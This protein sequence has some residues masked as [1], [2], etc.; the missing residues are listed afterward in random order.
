MA[1]SNTSNLVGSPKQIA[2]A[3]DIRALAKLPAAPVGL[4]RQFFGWLQENRPAGD[5]KTFNHLM[6]DRFPSADPSKAM[7]L[8]S[9]DAALRPVAEGALKGCTSASRWIDHRD[10]PEDIW[11]PALWDTLTNQPA[12]R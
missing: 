8:S 6:K 4:L 3:E 5:L 1:K 12:T 10:S 9:M 7:D 11:A 2:W